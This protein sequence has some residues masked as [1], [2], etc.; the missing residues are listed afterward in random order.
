MIF[1]GDNKNINITEGEPTYPY[2]STTSSTGQTSVT[3]PSVLGDDLVVCSSTEFP[4]SNLRQC[5]EP[6]YQC[7]GYRDCE[8][9]SDE[10]GCPPLVCSAS[11]FTCP[12]VRECIDKSL[13]C[14]GYTDCGDGSDEEDC[15][16]NV[17]TVS[18]TGPV[19]DLL[20]SY[21][22]VYEKM[23]NITHSGR[24]VWQSTS[25]DD[26]YLLY[27]GKLIIYIIIHWIIPKGYFWYINNQISENGEK[28]IR[29]ERKGQ[30]L[31]PEQ[32]WN[33]YDEKYL[34]SKD[35]SNCK[36]VRWT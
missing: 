22:G 25:R 19:A 15:Y 24:P 4:C 29:S 10:T 21:L 30:L 31:V 20:P 18:S 16:P 28:R 33:Y 23:T 35:F 7:D 9:G 13:R 26:R 3:L 1:G 36:T 8:D 6:S 14:N 34:E 2:N 17:L 11:Q 12:T 5:I 32:G 27:Q